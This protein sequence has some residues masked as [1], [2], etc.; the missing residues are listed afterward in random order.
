MKLE[1]ALARGSD[2]IEMVRIMT[3]VFGPTWVEMEPEVIWDGMEDRLG[4]EPSRRSKDKIMAIRAMVKSDAPWQQWPAFMAVA[5]A[6]ND[7]SCTPDAFQSCSPAEIAYATSIMKKFNEEAIFSGDV[8]TAMALMLANE[9]IIW[10]PDEYVA[11]GVN[12]TLEQ[13]VTSANPEAF[14]AIKAVRKNFF[15]KRNLPA[16]E[17]DEEDPLDQH[18]LRLNVMIA[19]EEA[20][21]A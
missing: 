13:L 2:P 15:E 6:L 16:D 17:L 19:Y 12:D 9:G 5:L 1:K 4:Y 14:Q 10:V 18:T 3:E 20:E 21:E 7:I 11:E 8:R